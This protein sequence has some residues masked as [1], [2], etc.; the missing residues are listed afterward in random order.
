M[1]LG[2]KK[3]SYEDQW[4]RI[5]DPGM[6]PHSYAHL[7]F[8]KGAQNIQ[9]KKGSLFN[10]CWEKWLSACRKQKLEPYLSLSTNINSK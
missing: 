10:Q 6:N 7:N 3:N 2:K 5:E 8:N 9:W 1:A 4:N